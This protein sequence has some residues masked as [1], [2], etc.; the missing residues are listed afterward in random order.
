MPGRRSLVTIAFLGFALAATV[1]VVLLERN[2]PALSPVLLRFRPES[3]ARLEIASPGERTVIERGEKRWN[4]VKPVKDWA[5]QKGMSEVAVGLSK[6]TVRE[7]IGDNHMKDSEAGLSASKAIG[8]KLDLRGDAT[9]AEQLVFGRPGPFENTVYARLSG[10][11]ERRGTQLVETSLRPVVV[12]PGEQLRDRK[13][14]PFAATDVTSYTFRQGNLDVELVRAPEAPRWFIKRPIQCRAN[15]DIVYSLL[16]E[17]G[18]MRAASFIEDRA[19]PAS[20]Q[21][22]EG[23]ALFDIQTRK[24]S[25]VKLT[26]EPKLG[27]G[28]ETMLAHVAGRTTVLEIA[29]NF[30]SRLPRNLEQFRFPN[31]IEFDKDS[32][33]R[34]KIESREDPDVELVNDGRR[35]SLASGGQKRPANEERLKRMLDALLAEPVLDFRSNSVADLARYG[36]DRPDVRVSIVT[37]SVEAELYDAY[38]RELGKARLEG[39]NPTSVPPPKV[40]VEQYGL[41]FRAGADGVMNA[42]LAGSP[43]VY[44]VDPALL[45]SAIPTHPL[46]WRDLQVLGFSLFEVRGIEVAEAGQPELKLTYDYLQNQWTGTVGGSAI[47]NLDARAAELLASTLGSLTARDF[48]SR[49]AAALDALRRPVCVVKLRTAVRPGEPETQRTLRMAPAGGG[50]DAE[51]FYGQFDGDPDVFVL[52]AGTYG[53]IVAPVVKPR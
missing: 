47:G 1:G 33:A 37:S 51:F 32:V 8:L 10:H 19:L 18:A 17:L 16:E 46:K 22:N 49:R 5:D 6:M 9:K 11:R 13:L 2:R 40:N 4:F 42:N 53:R 7:S 23:A 14:F 39:R 50:A 52:D 44:G 20:A 34:I 29:D 30:A 41:A 12:A 43:F 36:L 26:L 38:Q 3:L 25:A 45:T 24:G 31:L 28:R 48:L 35:W 21:M 27:R 15:D